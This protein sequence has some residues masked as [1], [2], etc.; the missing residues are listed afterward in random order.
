MLIIKNSFII[1]IFFSKEI[2]KFK[3]G[4]DEMLHLLHKQE[5]TKSAIIR[6][7]DEFFGFASDDQSVSI[8]VS[9]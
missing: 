2:D 7:V 1:I 5:V 9:M 4:V 8:A 6:D 3:N